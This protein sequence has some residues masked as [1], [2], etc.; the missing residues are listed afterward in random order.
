MLVSQG[1]QGSDG[2]L[3][4]NFLALAERIPIQILEPLIE[5]WTQPFDEISE[6]AVALLDKMPAEYRRKL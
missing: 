4:E 3:M 5:G 2:A 6:R 1:N